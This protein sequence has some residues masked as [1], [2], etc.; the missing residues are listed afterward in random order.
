MIKEKYLPEDYPTTT[1]LEILN[2]I[3]HKKVFIF[4]Y[5]YFMKTKGALMITDSV[6]WYGNFVMGFHENTHTDYKIQNK[7]HPPTSTC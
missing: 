6:V 3:L 1:I 4:G 7:H 5:T 2:L